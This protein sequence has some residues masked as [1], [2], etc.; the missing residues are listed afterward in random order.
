MVY[1]IG[2]IIFFILLILGLSIRGGSRK[3]KYPDKYIKGLEAIIEGK[4]DESIKYFKKVVESDT[5]N[6]DAYLHLGNL[7]REKG[8]LSSAMKIHKNLL[9]NPELSK[10]EKE[11]VQSALAADYLKSHD[12]EKAIPL[13]ESLYKRYPKDKKPGQ[14]L[15]MLYEKQ[16]SWDNAYNTAKTI[17]T[18]RKDLANYTTYIA[19]KLIEKDISKAKKFISLGQKSEI[20]YAHYLYGKVLITEG[21]ENSGI[22]YIKKSISL[23]P[24]RAY[25]YLPILEEYMFNKGE[26]GTIEPYLKNL[27]KENPD[28][29]EILNSYVSFL[30]KKGDIDKAKETLD[31]TVINLELIRPEILAKVASAYKGVDTEKALEYISETQKLLN[32]VKRFK[33]SVCGNEFDEFTWKCPDCDTPGTIY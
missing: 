28:N 2:I 19:S 33:C 1:L 4:I 12:W 16:E 15:L 8:L 23:D 7:L 11:R 29:W 3:V 27:I 18:D 6:R 5:T 25:L 22:D 24:K 13:Y 20:P 30:K 21:N 9:V 31:E 32:K 17:Y 14:I 10:V 26:F